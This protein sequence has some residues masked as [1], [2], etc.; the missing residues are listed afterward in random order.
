[1]IHACAMTSLLRWNAWQVGL[2]TVNH[3][4]SLKLGCFWATRANCA[5]IAR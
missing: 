3:H 5:A 2:T 1:M 4:A